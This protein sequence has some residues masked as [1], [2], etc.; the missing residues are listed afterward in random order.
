MPEYEL[1]EL[2]AK[3]NGRTKRLIGFIND[4]MFDLASKE[5]DVVLEILQNIKQ[6]LPKP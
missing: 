3:L 6:K 5:L 4:D 2:T 1:I